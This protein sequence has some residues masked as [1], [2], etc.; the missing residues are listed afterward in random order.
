MFNKSLVQLAILF[1]F[2]F[3]SL[4]TEAKPPK[5]EPK[6]TTVAEEEYPGCYEPQLTQNVREAFPRWYEQNVRTIA[7]SIVKARASGDWHNNKFGYIVF[8]TKNKMVA[9]ECVAM[10][11]DVTK[12]NKNLEAGMNSAGCL[13]EV[14]MNGVTYFELPHGFTTQWM[15]VAAEVLTRSDIDFVN[16]ENNVEEAMRNPKFKEVLA[17]AK[18]GLVLFS[19]IPKKWTTAARELKCSQIKDSVLTVSSDGKSTLVPAS[20]KKEVKKQHK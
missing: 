4:T 3:S 7:E 15:K 6:E 1:A 14:H 19:E 17:T 18:F 2:V 5:H 10:P 11:G 8:A 9:A 20:T 16:P 13:G 12:V